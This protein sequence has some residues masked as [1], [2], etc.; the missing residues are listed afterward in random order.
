MGTVTRHPGYPYANGELLDGTNDLE[1]DF[2]NI[3][4]EINGNLDNTNIASDAN[5]VGTKL[6]DDTVP[7]GKMQDDA[8]TTA[9]MATAAVSSY[10]L[11]TATGATNLDASSD[12]VF[13][14]IEGLSALTIT[15]GSS[16]DL[17]VMQF[18]GAVKNANNLALAFTVS[19]N[20]SDEDS[21]ALAYENEGA[22]TTYN[23]PV[24]WTFFKVAGT[25]S[26]LSIKARYRRT[27]SSF[28]TDWGSVIDTN[29][30]FCVRSIPIK[31]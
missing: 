20:G 8:I 6:K 17:L 24:T 25:T 2:N 11:T 18:T 22:T 28:T 27:G 26:A 1:V 31:A 23:V 10:G 13:H 4:T 5:I 16:S 14:D 3:V 30:T 21:F 7:T 19:I 9:K 29:R 15:P 12:I